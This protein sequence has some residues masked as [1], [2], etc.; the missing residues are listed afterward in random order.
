MELLKNLETELIPSRDMPQFKGGDNVTVHY[1]IVEGD[2]SRIQL[3]RGDVL[4]KKEEV[5]LKH[6][7]FGKFLTELV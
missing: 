4:Q 3:F 7:L 2:K 5:V 1:K 6:L